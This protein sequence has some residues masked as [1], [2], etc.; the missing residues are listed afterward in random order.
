MHELKKIEKLQD[1][2]LS[3][4]LTTTITTTTA[5][6]T[7]EV[8]DKFEQLLKAETFKSF[9]TRNREEKKIRDRIPFR[10]SIPAAIDMA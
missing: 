4:F 5:T 10:Y 7:V 1:V 8:K 2:E 6:R 9:D 3:P